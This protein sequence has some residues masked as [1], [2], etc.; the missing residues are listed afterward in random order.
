MEQ[1]LNRAEEHVATPIE[2]VI[3]DAVPKYEEFLEDGGSQT[4]TRR[5]FAVFLVFCYVFLVLDER[6]PCV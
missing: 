6:M 3:A 1:Q 5:R 2:S 4:E